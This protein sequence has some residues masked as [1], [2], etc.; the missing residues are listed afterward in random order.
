[1]PHGRRRLLLHWKLWSEGSKEEFLQIS[2]QD[3]RGRIVMSR[4]SVHE[5]LYV[6][7]N[8]DAEFPRA[9]CFGLPKNFLYPLQS[10]FF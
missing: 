5:L 6:V 2:S 1:M 9:L 4:G 10:K 8:G 7:K 3:K